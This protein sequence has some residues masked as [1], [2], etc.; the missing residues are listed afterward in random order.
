MVSTLT[1]MTTQTGELSK[2][3]EKLTER[4]NKNEKETSLKMAQDMNDVMIELSTSQGI[5][6]SAV[7]KALKIK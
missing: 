5:I 6:A 4:A 3:S 2:L 1:E 7:Q